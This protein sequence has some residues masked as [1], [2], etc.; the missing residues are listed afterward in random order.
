MPRTCRSTSD[1]HERTAS[2][3]P[4]R[5]SSSPQ[6]RRPR[7]SWRRRRSGEPF[8]ARTNYV[9][10]QG[11]PATTKRQC[12]KISRFAK[13]MCR[14]IDPGR[15]SV[16]EDGLRAPPGRKPQSIVHTRL[17]PQTTGGPTTVL[18]TESTTVAT[19]LLT[20]PSRCATADIRHFPV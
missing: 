10:L 8:S 17:A 7:Q 11:L 6:V 20:P 13:R 4:P 15:E 19:R 5:W 2:A 1:F 9:I 18:D 3:P 14:S 16:G 12:N